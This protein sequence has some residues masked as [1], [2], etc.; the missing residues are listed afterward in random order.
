MDNAF[1]SA[2][3]VRE[4]IIALAVVGALIAMTGN[5]WR[6]NGRLTPGAGKIVARTGYALSWGALALFLAVLFW[7]R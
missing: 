1:L 2:V 3:S 4:M 6:A 5:I 7:G